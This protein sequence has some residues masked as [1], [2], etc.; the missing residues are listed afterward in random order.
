M[1][2]KLHKAIIVAWLKF[3]EY[4][5]PLWT[6]TPISGYAE[7]GPYHCGECKYL[8][9]RTEGLPY[10]GPE[11][12]GRCTHPIIAIDPRIKVDE[13]GR[14]IVNIERGCCEFVDDSGIVDIVENPL[15]KEPKHEG[16]Y[17]F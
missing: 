15:L 9:G 7:R 4:V 5:K 13:Q 10:R 11:G 1:P 14:K 12:R 2:Q 6:G 3:V 16:A 8:K 17:K